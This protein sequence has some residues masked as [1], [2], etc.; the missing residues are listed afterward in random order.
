MLEGSAG[1][2]SSVDDAVNGAGLLEVDAVGD[3]EDAS[4]GVAG[5]DEAGVA[6]KL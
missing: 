6:S 4:V 5:D 2:V 3:V 1:C